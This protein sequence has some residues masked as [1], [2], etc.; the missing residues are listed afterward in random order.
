MA[1]SSGYSSADGGSIGSFDAGS[2]RGMASVADLSE[3]GRRI[4]EHV[5]GTSGAYEGAAGIGVAAAEGVVVDPYTGWVAPRRGAGEDVVESRAMCSARTAALWTGMNGGHPRGLHGGGSGGPAVMRAPAASRTAPRAGQVS[6]GSSPGSSFEAGPGGERELS[7]SPP[8]GDGQCWWPGPGELFDIGRNQF[9]D[10]VDGLIVPSWPYAAGMGAGGG[11]RLV[12]GG[13][14]MAGGGTVGGSGEDLSVHTLKPGAR[15]EVASHAPVTSREFWVPGM[16]ACLQRV[17][18]VGAVDSHKGLVRLHFFDAERSTHESFWFHLRSLRLAPPAPGMPYAPLAPLGPEPAIWDTPVEPVSPDGVVV[19]SY[20]VPASLP[21]SPSGSPRGS[22]PVGRSDRWANYGDTNGMLTRPDMAVMVEG[23]A[24]AA[25][26]RH[27]AGPD[28]IKPWASDGPWG[29]AGVGGGGGD[30]AGPTRPGGGTAGGSAGH[31][32]ATARL[33]RMQCVAEARR[34]VLLL[35]AR[36]SPDAGAAKGA[37]EDAVTGRVEEVMGDA[38]KDEG[39]GAS[40]SMASLSPSPYSGSIP[41]DGLLVP[42]SA[43]AMGAGTMGTMGAMGAGAMCAGAATPS[44]WG[45]ACCWATLFRAVGKNAGV[46]VLLRLLSAEHLA[47]LG[48][49]PR[50]HSAPQPLDVL[51]PFLRAALALS[52]S[53]TS[54]SSGSRTSVS[55][56]IRAMP[57]TA[58]TGAGG[59]RRST[60]RGRRTSSSTSTLLLL[61]SAL[62]SDSM[63]PEAIAVMADEGGSHSPLATSPTVSFSRSVQGGLGPVQGGLGSVQRGSGSAPG[64]LGSSVIHVSAQGGSGAVG[65]LSGT[66]GDVSVSVPGGGDASRPVKGGDSPRSTHQGADVAEESPRSPDGGGMSLDQGASRPLVD[67]SRNVYPTSDARVGG[68]DELVSSSANRHLRRQSRSSHSGGSGGRRLLRLLCEYAL[69]ALA[70]PWDPLEPG[71]LLESEHPLLPGVGVGQPPGEIREVH[72]PGAEALVV[73][74]DERCHTE[75]YAGICGLYLDPACKLPVYTCSG[76]GGGGSA[77]GGGA[78]GGVPQFRS[79]A[80]R[81]SRMWFRYSP[82]GRA[83]DPSSSSGGGAA[84]APWGYRLRV[85]PVSPP[86]ADA[87]S[88]ELPSATLAFWLLRWLLREMP[89]ALLKRHGPAVVSALLSFATRRSTPAHARLVAVRLLIHV[90]RLVGPGHQPQGCMRSDAQDEGA[91]GP[92]SARHEDPWENKDLRKDPAC[93]PLEGGEAPGVGV[94]WGET[95]SVAGAR[96]GIRG[97]SGGQEST[98]DPLESALLD[99]ALTSLVQGFGSEVRQGGGWPGGPGSTGAEEGGALAG[100]AA[101]GIP[102]GRD[103]HPPSSADHNS[104]SGANSAAGGGKAGAWRGAVPLDPPTRAL[105]LS[106]V[107]SHLGSL[108][109]LMTAQFRVERNDVT[110]FS[111]YLQCLTELHSVAMLVTSQGSGGG[112]SAGGGSRRGGLGPGGQPAR[113]RAASVPGATRTVPSDVIPAD[114]GVPA[115][116]PAYVSELRGG[117][118]HLRIATRPAGGGGES[119]QQGRAREGIR[120]SL[121][122]SLQASVTA[123]GLPRAISPRSPLGMS[124]RSHS[125]SSL[126]SLGSGGE[127]GHGE[128][129]HGEGGGGEGAE[130]AGDRVARASMEVP[131][132]GGLLAAARGGRR[133]SLELPLRRTWDPRRSS[134]G[135]EDP[136]VAGVG[137]GSQQQQQQPASMDARRR[138][139]AEY[140]RSGSGSAELSSSS[141][142]GSEEAP[143]RGW[144]RRRRRR[145]GQRRVPPTQLIIV[146]AI[147]GAMDEL[148]PLDEGSGGGGVSGKHHIGRG[149]RGAGGELDLGLGLGLSSGGAPLMGSGG[150]SSWRHAPPGQGLGQGQPLP[151]NRF[152]DVTAQLQELVDRQGGGKLLVVDP[153][154]P[155]T[156]LLDVPDPAPGLPKLLRLRCRVIN[157]EDFGHGGDRGGSG[158]DSDEGEASGAREGAG[159]GGE[160]GWA[161]GWGGEGGRPTGS[162]SSSTGAGASG[163]GSPQG[164]VVSPGSSRDGDSSSGGGE[165]DLLLAVQ[166]SAT[167]WLSADPWMYHKVTPLPR[168]A[169][170]IPSG[171]EMVPLGLGGADDSGGA[172][173]LF[174]DVGGYHGASGLRLSYDNL[175]V[176]NSAQV[177]HSVRANVC[178][179]GGRWYYEVKLHTAGLMQIGWATA[180]FVHSPA[181]SCGVGDDDASWAYDGFRRRFWHGDYVRYGASWRPGDIVGVYADLE[182]RGEDGRVQGVLSYD[183]NGQDLGNAAVGVQIGEGIFPA[184][185]LS[186]GDSFRF[187]FSL[188]GMV[189]GQRALRMGFLPLHRTPSGSSWHSKVSQAVEVIAGLQGSLPS[190]PRS[191]LREAVLRERLAVQTQWL[192]PGRV[193]LEAYRRGL[194]FPDL[195]HAGGDFTV[196][197]WV[198]LTEPPTGKWRTLFFKGRDDDHTRTPAVFLHPESLRVAFCVSTTEY[199]NSCIRSVRPVAYMAWTHL[200]V[201]REGRRSRVFLDGTLD[202]DRVMEGAA[203]PNPHPFHLGRTPPGVKKAE[204]YYAGMVGFVDALCFLSRAVHAD[205]VA[206]SYAHMAPRYVHP[207]VP[208]PPPPSAAH[209]RAGVSFLE[210]QAP[211]ARAAW[212]A[213]RHNTGSGTG[214]PSMDPATRAASVGSYGSGGG[215]YAPGGGGMG[216][217]LY[218][219]PG[220]AP[221]PLVHA[222]GVQRLANSVPGMP[223]VPPHHFIAYG[224]IRAA[225]AGGRSHEGGGSISSQM[226]SQPLSL[227]DGHLQGSPSEGGGGPAAAWAAGREAGQDPAHA[228][229]HARDAGTGARISVAI[230]GMEGNDAGGQGG[231]VGSPRVP[232]LPLGLSRWLHLPCCDDDDDDDDDEEEDDEEDGDEEGTW[233]VG[234]GHGYSGGR[235]TERRR[236]DS[237]CSDDMRALLAP[238]TPAM[239]EEMGELIAALREDQGVPAAKLNLEVLGPDAPVLQQLPLL[240]GV[241]LG[242]L[243]LRLAVLKLLNAQLV[244]VLPFVDMSLVEEPWSL[245][246]ALARLRG[247]IFLETKMVIWERML[248]AITSGGERPQVSLNR[249]RALSVTKDL[250]GRKSLFGQAFRQLLDVKPACLRDPER[251]WSVTLE[252]EGAEDYGGPYRESISH[253]CN[254]L[255]SEML[256]LLVP[257][258]NGR[259][260]VGSNREK[261]LPNPSCGSSTDLALFR[262]LGKLMGIALWCKTSLNLDLPSVVWKPLVGLPLERGDLMAVDSTCCRA[263]DWLRHIDA[264]G[265]TPET[266][267]DVIYDTFSVISVSGQEVELLP[268]GASLPVTWDNRVLYCD[269]VEDF[270]LHA[271]DRQVAAIREGLASLVPARYL[272]LFTHKELE[273]RVCGHANVDIDLLQQHTTYNGISPDEPHVQYFWRALREF[274]PELRRRFVRFVWGRS[275]LPTS[276]AE[277]SRNFELQPLTRALGMGALADNYLPVAHTCFFSL[278]LPAYRRADA[279]ALPSPASF[280][281]TFCGNF[282]GECECAGPVHVAQRVA[283][284]GLTAQAVKEIAAKPA[285]AG[286]AGDAPPIT[287]WADMLKQHTTSTTS[288]VAAQLQRQTLDLRE[289]AEL[290]KRSLNVIVKNFTMEEGE[291]SEKLT[292]AFE[293]EILGRMGLN[294]EIELAAHRLPRARGKAGP[295]PLLLTFKTP[296]DKISFLRR[297]KRLEK[298]LFT[299]DDDLTLVQQ[300]RRRELWPTY[301]QL[302]QTKAGQPVYWKGAA[303]YVGHKPWQATPAAPATPDAPA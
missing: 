124:E 56:G 199:W 197:L 276:G 225:G 230:A 96:D 136:G 285:P 298:T 45:V 211:A 253:M 195:H 175:L 223:L 101:A 109:G 183:L 38:S 267:N 160:F 126:A 6:C 236:W 115:P 181:E 228:G 31:A 238:W 264:E 34:A 141:E 240:R 87:R 280:H 178:V 204:N 300:Q 259:L 156:S 249:V 174:G 15:L 137:G 127:G 270:H 132:S 277:F 203:L 41:V 93:R 143:E 292:R 129:G 176:S 104:S 39:T 214:V 296:A 44:S 7:R 245:A 295:P 281:G 188:E 246:H 152:I 117:S 286:L 301:L 113:A 85:F 263:L 179:T 232:G 66:L 120:G 268:G 258:T 36:C 208:N 92:D 254:E 205:E 207:C 255:Q 134:L 256:P 1:G 83:A 77:A 46:L 102:F 130:G 157:H 165:R 167:L 233:D 173:A 18:T 42:P 140:A 262:F 24:G 235:E 212:N 30:P 86:L 69:G 138:R 273:L 153:S 290:A 37:K 303:I 13:G 118:G 247:V 53:A 91:V 40:G 135:W 22:S 257:C 185:S 202:S 271:S 32:D 187:A 58:T 244:D 248:S 50:P 122:C 164:Q 302:R 8:G 154:H 269:L 213:T 155:L 14:V 206:A 242:T 144:G 114:A 49:L 222:R 261:F 88:L 162:G 123:G 2:P 219:A 111:S 266:F 190:L 289:E 33:L 221:A 75:P 227:S 4:R 215:A 180:Q 17:G 170:A 234:A 148:L 98:L 198:Y 274:T 291:N 147:F 125:A 210:G 43:A 95:F 200:V 288:A 62:D 226:S 71:V 171:V 297:R 161:H 72:F 189:Y 196:S 29:T 209:A 26:S 57:A 142:R 168:G 54:V 128:G 11:S 241:P 193:Q 52:S 63:D 172:G 121:S 23:A 194:S 47:P 80:V 90:L 55:A 64:G 182:A 294:G 186:M 48:W 146:H 139:S 158:G 25:G 108:R 20:T 260:N 265:V 73:V 76:R 218:P 278:E 107:G 201:C 89:E 133:H 68:G 243:K 252:G 163:G 28:K 106:L 149:G 299:L 224:G 94:S 145:G 287:T 110:P 282:Q 97:G 220:L 65:S 3:R 12:S 51:T 60:S 74:F 5:F 177:F 151:A 192:S 250:E 217:P 150:S 112:S 105:L 79:F 229:A 9:A 100:A 159:R 27:V 35:A 78:I 293:R 283:A 284:V 239:D 103:H 67:E 116:A 131:T 70:R 61:A 169:E 82:T 237:D 99:G 216:T 19:R 272:P 231:G 21:G 59:S 84:L 184:A 191:F 166:E 10:E 16:D 119:P 81:S 279:M 275:R 251:A